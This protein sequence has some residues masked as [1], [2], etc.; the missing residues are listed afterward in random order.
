MA[1]EE[2]D[3]EF[4]NSSTSLIG[5]GDPT[6]TEENGVD[7]A[8]PETEKNSPTEK[9]P[10]AEKYRREDGALDADKIFSDLKDLQK[11]YQGLRKKLSDRENAKPVSW[12]DLR[13]ELKELG[14]LS[15]E[16]EKKF[17]ER[18]VGLLGKIGARKEQAVEFLKELGTLGAE[19]NPKEFYSKELAKL[20]NERDALISDLR[21]FRDAARNSGQWSQE[22]VAALETATQTADGVRLI[23][24]ILHSTNLRSA[25]KFSPM[26][27]AKGESA[28]VS[29][30][31]KITAYEAA[32]ALS[33][34]DP[35][36]GKAEMR[37]LNRLYGIYE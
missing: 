2:E 15:G 23:H 22:D 12:E 19:D 9:D 7:G 21:R 20:G 16:E 28:N 36:A 24:K 25:G 8:H 17:A 32:I 31:E 26:A 11:N 5:D 4:T 10:L 1:N 30:E 18:F 35:A 34:R 6:G 3:G 27:P 33:R 13:G 14:E 37:R 29:N